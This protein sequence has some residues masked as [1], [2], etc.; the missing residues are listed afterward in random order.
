MKKIISTLLCIL[1]CASI[2]AYGGIMAGQEGKLKFAK[3]KYFDIIYAE[4][5]AQ[6]ANILFEQ[7]DSV[8][9]EL[10]ELYM[11]PIPFRTTVSISPST[12]QFNASYTQFPFNCISIYDTPVTESFMI[13]SENVI[14]TF[15]H[16]LIHAFTFNSKNKFWHVIGCIFGDIVNPM[17]LTTGT[18]GWLEGATVSTE[19]NHGEGRRNSELHNHLIKQAK[20]EGKFPK[21]SEIQGARDTYPR[22]SLSY[23]FGGAFSEYLQKKY[24]FEKYAQFFYN[25]TNI[26]RPS[27]LFYFTN[28][29]KVYGI[30]IKDAWKDFCETIE[31]PDVKTRP[32]EEEWCSLPEKPRFINKNRDNYPTVTACKN[33]FIFYD[34]YKSKVIYINEEGKY[35]TLLK[36]DSI[37]RINVSPDGKMLSVSCS[38]SNY[39]VAKNYIAVINLESFSRYIFNEQSLRDAT[40]FYKDEKYYLAAV[41][42]VSQNTYL[43]IYE[44]AMN[45][46][47][48]ILAANG[49]KEFQAPYGDLIYSPAGSADGK[50]FFGYKHNLDLDICVYDSEK[51]EFFTLNIPEF[52]HENGKTEIFNLNCSVPG[53]LSFSFTQKGTMPRLGIIK[54]DEN[55][56]NISVQLGAKDSSGGI[57]NSSLF[58][59]GK[60]AVFAGHFYE[61]YRILF[62]DL[63]KMPFYETNASTTAFNTLT[64]QKLDF[65]IDR[66]IIWKSLT[67]RFKEPVEKPEEEKLPVEKE[68]KRFSAFA[69]NFTGPKGLFIPFPSSYSYQFV[70]TINQ[71][72]GS[73]FYQVGKSSSLFGA[74]FA[75]S[76][77]W[78]NPIYIFSAGLNPFS[79]SADITMELNGKT[80]YLAY[81]LVGNVNFD[82]DGFKQASGS[83][84][85][86]HQTPFIG[87]TQ[88]GLRNFSTLAYGRSDL[89]ITE[90]MLYNIILSENP[91]QSI[92]GLTKGPSNSNYM[93]LFEKIQLSLGTLNYDNSEKQSIYGWQMDLF[94]TFDDS[95]KIIE[96]N[97][98][99]SSGIENCG[100]DFGFFIPRL[101]PFYTYGTTLNLP[102][103]LMGA[104]FPNN[105]YFGAAKAS[106]T[107]FSTEIQKSTNWLP[108]FYFD[109]FTVEASYTGKISDPSH[110]VLPSFAILN[111][112]YYVDIVKKGQMKYSDEL[113]LT[114][115]LEMNPNI[116]YLASSSFKFTLNSELIYRFNP[117][118]FL[119][120][121]NFNFSIFGVTIF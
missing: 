31:V 81:D 7:A 53:A 75:S 43:R 72:D 101:L 79:M 117:N 19:S 47:G 4:K 6:T 16:E 3:T 45:E 38:A 27:Y 54:F 109:R 44:I 48:R 108:L 26:Q 55:L 33:G 63:E 97:V 77:P 64:E 37:S 88:I 113:K 28:F 10:S 68:S 22:N 82:T 30:K 13:F 110:P 107:L 59:D 111:S 102:L 71:K 32:W 85:F 39:D 83:I 98:I 18:T 36:C 115:S 66:T 116:G 41:K 1:S 70:P 60:K 67:E 106:V 62:A 11:V 86:T 15:R 91:V 17:I 100:V 99:N 25:G 87:N 57:F 69:Y 51:N 121:K 93:Y 90:A 73:I 23:Y 120:E 78:Q 84:N 50:L 65:E 5:S 119:G 46:N 80:G 29:K 9:E 8:Y 24:G 58:D 35:R 112:P 76:T 74:T 94:V 42:T 96:K 89:T 103:K 118:E 114:L 49:I 104:I 56:A 14:N 21:Y 12:D 34:A 61:D 105:Y 40:V 95:C 2:F 52:A 92:F 20:I